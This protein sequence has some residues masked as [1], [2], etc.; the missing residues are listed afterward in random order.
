MAKMSGSGVVKGSK[1]Q[2]GFGKKQTG[3]SA[4]VGKKKGSFGKM[5][6]STIKG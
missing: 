3:F 5:G 6:A 4:T 1:G 2:P